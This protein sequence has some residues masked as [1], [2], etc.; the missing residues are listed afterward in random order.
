MHKELQFDV[1]GS[2]ASV[3]SAIPKD[4]W[5]YISILDLS[6]ELKLRTS[7]PG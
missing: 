3:L 7:N 6:L 1:T 2:L 5:G 4:P